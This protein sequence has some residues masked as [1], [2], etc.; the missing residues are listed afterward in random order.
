MDCVPALSGEQSEPEFERPECHAVA[1][2]ATADYDVTCSNEQRQ[3]DERDNLNQLMD[4]LR[5]GARDASFSNCSI[6][7]VK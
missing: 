3:Q 1:S 5:D 4:R 7:Y 6:L 2:A